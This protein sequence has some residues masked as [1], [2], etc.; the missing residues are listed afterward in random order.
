[1]NFYLKMV[2][3]G[4]FYRITFYVYAKIGQVNGGPPPGSATDHHHH[5]HHHHR[6]TADLGS[7]RS[8]QRVWL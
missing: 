4:A 6:R 3:F 7:V 5:H 8:K 2:D 1:M